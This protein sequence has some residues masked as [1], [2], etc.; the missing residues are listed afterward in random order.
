MNWF[1]AGGTIQPVEDAV[2][3]AAYVPG[4]YDHDA[5]PVVERGT[6]WGW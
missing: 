5:G 1:C 2:G 4:E 6:G 3:G